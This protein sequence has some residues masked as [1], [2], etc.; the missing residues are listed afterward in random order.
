MEVR[1]NGPTTTQFGITFQRGF[2]YDIA[3]D[4]A[5]AVSKSA[6][7]ELKQEEGSPSPVS[8]STVEEVIEE[9]V[10]EEE[11]LDYSSMTKKELQAHLTSLAIPFKKFD[12]KASLLDLVL[13]LDEEE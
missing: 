3:D 10:I 9:E 8:T 6:N 5:Q 13:S 2:W 11:S 4:M 12:S 1:N 7:F